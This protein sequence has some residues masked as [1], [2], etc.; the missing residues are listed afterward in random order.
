MGRN[1]IGKAKPVISK[2]AFKA[3]QL[4]LH[5]GVRYHTNQVLTT[6]PYFVGSW[7]SKK[8]GDIR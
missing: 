3:L 2:M 5:R 8:Q 7:P 1:T 6:E 4:M